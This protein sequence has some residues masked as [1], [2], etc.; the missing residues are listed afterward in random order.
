[1]GSEMIAFVQT[2]SITRN[3]TQ[4]ALSI[5]PFHDTPHDHFLFRFR[6]SSLTDPL[7]Y[8][9]VPPVQRCSSSSHV[10]HAPPRL[11]LSRT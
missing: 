6:I 11:R 4:S 9:A 10:Y 2:T 1:M 3:D 5:R 7:L 8:C